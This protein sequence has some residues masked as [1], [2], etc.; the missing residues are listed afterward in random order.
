MA[1]KKRQPAAAVQRFLNQLVALMEER[2]ISQAD[3][4]RRMNRPESYVSKILRGESNLTP[5]T[6]ERIAAAVG[7]DVSIHLVDPA[8]TLKGST[9]EPSASKPLTRNKEAEAKAVAVVKELPPEVLAHVLRLAPK[10]GNSAGR[11]PGPHYDYTQHLLLMAIYLVSGEAKSERE[12]AELVRAWAK[13]HKKLQ[14]SSSTLRRHFREQREVFLERAR[15]E[16][17]KKRRAAAGDEEPQPQ[18]PERVWKRASGAGAAGGGGVGMG[19]PLSSYE[20]V[21]R[22]LTRLYD[23]FR[24]P[25]EALESLR[26]PYVLEEVQKLAAAALAP[27]IDLDAVRGLDREHLAALRSIPPEVTMAARQFESAIC[28]K[29]ASALA[30]ANLVPDSATAQVARHV[31]AAQDLARQIPGLQEHLWMTRFFRD[32]Y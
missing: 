26:T 15:F 12:A 16:L 18:R 4:A 17:A 1:T 22:E 20:S 21:T 25:M 32:L 27:Q 3:L 19:Y 29:G 23:E 9:P 31:D 14:P 2:D 24:F 10:S 30:A 28:E 13:R 5:P 8:D 6:M 7:V 11:P